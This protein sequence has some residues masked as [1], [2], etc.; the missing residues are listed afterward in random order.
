MEQKGDLSKF[1]ARDGYSKGKPQLIE[2][3]WYAVK[4][5]F[6]LT[7]LPWPN[8]LKIGILKLFGAKMGERCYY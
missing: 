2:I 1:N 3:I 8:K 6:F 4:T 7:A 5:I